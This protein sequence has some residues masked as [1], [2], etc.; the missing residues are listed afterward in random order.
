M[1]LNM[2]LQQHE[3]LWTIWKILWSPLNL[4]N[5]YENNPIYLA[6]DVAMVSIFFITFLVLN[7]VLKQFFNRS[8]FQ[9]VRMVFRRQTA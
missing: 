7:N 2:F 1:E 6:Y 8:F 5:I 9:L 3:P 4:L